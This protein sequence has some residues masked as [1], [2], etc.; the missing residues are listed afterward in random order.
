MFQTFSVRDNGGTMGNADEWAKS[1]GAE[2]QATQKGELDAHGRVAMQRGIA[3]EQF[4]LLWQEVCVQF[5]EHCK[6][7][8][9]Q[10]KPERTLALLMHNANSFNIRPD[11]LPDIVN[12]EYHADTQRIKIETYS[13]AEWYLPQVVLEGTGQAI[14]VSHSSK[15]HIT[16]VDI[17]RVTLHRAI[18][19]K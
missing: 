16:P 12:G 1:L 11:A 10:L 14:L 19:G 6:A 9:D 8:N 15:K 2:M 4:P 17:A 7:Y 3:A 13:G 18:M 5:T